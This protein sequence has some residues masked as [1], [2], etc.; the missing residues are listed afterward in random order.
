MRI[1][2]VIVGFI[3]VLIVLLVS[4]TLLKDVVPSFDQVVNMILKRG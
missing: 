4:M 1:E 2:Y 3:L